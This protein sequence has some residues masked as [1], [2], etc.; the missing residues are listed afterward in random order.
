MSTPTPHEPESGLKK[1]RLKYGSSSSNNR[2][3]NIRD[4]ESPDTDEDSLPDL[5][6]QPLFPEENHNKELQSP[7]DD[8]RAW[9]L[10]SLPS[11]PTV[12]PVKDRRNEYY[13]LKRFIFM[14][15]GVPGAPALSVRTQRICG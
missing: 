3:Y 11:F 13:N 7:V 10:H 2:R 12:V 4:R 15:L 6:R 14:S 9:N 8:D 5:K 1:S